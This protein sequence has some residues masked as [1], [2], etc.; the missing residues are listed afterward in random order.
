[1]Q[2]D[3]YRYINIFA[4]LL[5]FL[6]IFFFT[7]SLWY[8]FYI[9]LKRNVINKILH[10]CFYDSKDLDNFVRMMSWFPFPDSSKLKYTYT[11]E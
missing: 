10:T 2:I 6:P 9:D 8:Y 3:I 5:A 1:M 11:R 4:E 7:V